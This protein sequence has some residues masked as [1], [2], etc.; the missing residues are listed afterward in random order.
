MRILFLTFLLASTVCASRNF[1]QFSV[2]HATKQILELSQKHNQI[3]AYT[4]TDCEQNDIRLAVQTNNHCMLLLK[5]HDELID[6]ISQ[7]NTLIKDTRENI[8]ELELA[9]KY[10]MD[11]QGNQGQ[12]AKSKF[13]DVIR[14]KKTELS[15][16]EKQLNLL[17]KAE[18]MNKKN[19]LTCIKKNS[20]LTE[21]ILTELL[22][23]KL[24][25]NNL[26][27]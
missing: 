2:E 25:V 17:E 22:A 4:D 20:Q 27:T 16:A 3:L 15:T 14:L 5:S 21:I 10:A 7:L 18:A 8:E 19:I 26:V 9:K 1:T 12:I 23:C 6:T 24:L 11:P 13:T